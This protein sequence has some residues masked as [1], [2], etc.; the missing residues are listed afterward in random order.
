MKISLKR[1]C[2]YFCV[3]DFFKISCE[4]DPLDGAITQTNI[5]TVLD[6]N[7]FTN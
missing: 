4:Q 7:I 2:P 6:G 1:L 5:R 3:V